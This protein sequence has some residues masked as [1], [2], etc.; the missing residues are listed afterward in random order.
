[1]SLWF[2]YWQPFSRPASLPYT[3]KRDYPY[4]LRPFSINPG[5]IAG[6]AINLQ[7]QS[8][9]FDSEG[10]NEKAYI[11]TLYFRAAQLGSTDGVLLLRERQTGRLEKDAYPALQLRQSNSATIARSK[12]KYQ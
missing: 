6:A 9:V 2:Y 11:I 10:K 8:V 1:V 3:Y 5:K 12:E 7:Q 4:K